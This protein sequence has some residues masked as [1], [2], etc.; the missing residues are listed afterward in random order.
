MR[1]AVA[2]S[3]FLVTTALQAQSPSTARD[4]L[5]DQW[6]LLIRQVVADQKATDSRAHTIKLG[7]SIGWRHLLPPKDGYARDA[8]L[9]PGTDTVH[10]DEIDRGDVV[11][12]AILAAYP[13]K[14]PEEIDGCCSRG[15]LWRLGFVANLDVATLGEAGVV[16]FNRSIE[17]GV[18]LGLRMADNF[19]VATTIERVFSRVPRS[20]VQ[21]RQPL[22]RPM[23]EPAELRASDD[24]Y[25][26]SD[27]LT[28]LSL[29]FVYYVR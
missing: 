28:A 8:A 5:P 22:P 3:G 4:T 6:K 29:K 12:S 18:G 7:A 13:W 9:R 16:S 23:G 20:F 19:S 24:R 17:G 15:F 27:N 10:L 2:F 1:F 26:R 14:R 21:D 25:F 11:V